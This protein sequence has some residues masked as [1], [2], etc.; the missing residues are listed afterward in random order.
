MDYRKRPFGKVTETFLGEELDRVSAAYE[1][2]RW[3][4]IS[5]RYDL[6]G[7]GT[8]VIADKDVTRN[9]LVAIVSN[10]YDFSA[11]AAQVNAHGGLNAL[12][13]L[14]RSG[15]GHNGTFY[16][17]GSAQNSWIEH[18]RE[19]ENG[20]TGATHANIWV[21]SAGANARL[22]IHWLPGRPVSLRLF[23]LELNP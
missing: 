8:L 13:R 15:A 16:L 1:G 22:K 20:T 5:K 11:T 4:N 6:S 2:L 3:L 23:S 18:G 17:H 19:A 21:E 7:S 10:D 14:D 9:G 12:F